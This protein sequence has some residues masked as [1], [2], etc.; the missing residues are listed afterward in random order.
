[1]LLP[2]DGRFGCVQLV[3]SLQLLLGYGWLVVFCCM[4]MLML[5]AAGCLSTVDQECVLLDV[6]AVAAIYLS[7]VSLC[8]I[9]VVP[10]VPVMLRRRSW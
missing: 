7:P 8:A 1:M 3:M 2:V 10:C 6:F 4:L 9:V 5:V